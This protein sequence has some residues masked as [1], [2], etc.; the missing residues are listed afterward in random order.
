MQKEKLESLVSQ[1]QDNNEDFRRIK[2][3][4]N[5]TVEQG[6]TNYRHI[7]K[8]AF[9]SVID[10]CRRDP[11]KFN[12]LYYNL[13]QAATTTETR[14][15]EFDMIDQCNGLSSVEQLCYQQSANYIV[16]W[17]FLVGEAEKFFNDRV[18]ELKQVCISQLMEAFISASI[19]S[20]FTR[21]L[22]VDSE[23][24]SS[25]QTYGN[26]KEIRFDERI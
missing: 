24:V 6:L 7:L 18:N 4:V 23:A 20:Q 1:F 19:S 15:A 16:Y 2:E 26:E 8:I 25:M 22:Y 17:R 9:I 10:S 11:V 12:I 3:L 21:K 13:P 14:L 5:Q